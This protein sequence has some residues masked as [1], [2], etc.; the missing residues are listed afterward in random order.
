MSL[1]S[2]TTAA[3][4]CPAVTASTA[5]I[6]AFTGIAASLDSIATPTAGTLHA[7]GALGGEQSSET[8]PPDSGR[9]AF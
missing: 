3:T 5:S 1:P 7:K 8:L 2:C 9:G 6:A 4:A